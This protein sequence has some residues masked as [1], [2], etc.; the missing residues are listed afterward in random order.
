MEGD[1]PVFK[2][3]GTGASLSS[4]LTAS[5]QVLVSRLG[6]K[7]AKPIYL[8]AHESVA[9]GSGPQVCQE[10]RDYGIDRHGE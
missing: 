9:Q 3:S 6:G 7:M 1:E 10:M 8:I 5:V 2:D 4:H